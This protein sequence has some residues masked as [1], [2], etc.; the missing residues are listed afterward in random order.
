MPV[1]EGAWE[2]MSGGPVYPVAR[3]RVY[4]AKFGQHLL[5]LD[6]AVARVLNAAIRRSHRGQQ[7]AG[8]AATGLASAE[9]AL[10]LGLAGRGHF[11][12]ALRMVCAVGMVYGAC[13]LIGIG[14]RRERPFVGIEEVEGLVVH[15]AGRSFPSRHVASGVAMATIG[16][17][18]HPRLGQT[19][20]LLAWLLGLSRVAAGLHYPSDVLAGVALGRTVGALLRSSRRM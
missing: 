12:T 8:A 11:Q 9:V 16:H 4:V 1:G 5:A 17:A 19:M 14:W 7:V 2:G 13:E 20:A 3:G 15:R 18:V 10:M 6:A